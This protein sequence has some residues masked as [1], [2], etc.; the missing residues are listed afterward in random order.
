M[1][2]ANT[3]RKYESP[4][5]L[6][7]QSMIL[8]AAREMLD[9]GGY[10]GLTMRGLARKA[11]VA[12]G[13][14]YNLYGSKDD[15]VIA[16]VDDLLEGLGEEIT[17]RTPEPG[18]DAILTQAQVTGA[19]IQAAPAYAAAMTRIVMNAQDDARMVELVF[20][21]YYPA[22]RRCLH[23]AEKAGE[24]V[25]DVNVDAVARHMSGNSWG[26]ILLWVMG[27]L[28]IEQIV[29]ERERSALLVLIGITREPRR[30]QL[31]ER[32]QALS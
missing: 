6:A 31:E 11:G 29:R 2:Q 17:R 4:R 8:A 27:M 21:R 18:I 16:A 24:L 20:S 22:V 12:Q 28:P 25:E 5:Q 13:T 19:N 9:E 15:L 10:D 1:N 23:A 30:S 26:V 7:R 3:K 14:L 32:L